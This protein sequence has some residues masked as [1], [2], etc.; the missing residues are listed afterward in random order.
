[1]G[2]KAYLSQRAKKELIEWVAANGENYNLYRELCEKRG[3]TPYTPKYFHTWIYRRKGKLDLARADHAEEVRKMSV[4]S[5]ERRVEELE[6]DVGRI[7]AV[8]IAFENEKMHI[9][10]HCELLHTTT[11]DTLIKLSEQKRKLLEAIAKERNEWGREPRESE[12]VSVGESAR[13]IALAKLN[14]AT[15][16]TIID[17]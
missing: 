10:S 8:I 15:K 6:Q 4:Y 13:A 17:V 7:N 2:N 5:R 16:T 11:P 12:E 3:W 1:M 14:K 9:C